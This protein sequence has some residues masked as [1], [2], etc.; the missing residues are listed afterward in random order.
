[1]SNPNHKLLIKKIVL[2]R[3]VDKIYFESIFKLIKGNGKKMQQKLRLILFIIGLIFISAV[4]PKVFGQQTNDVRYITLPGSKLWIDGTSNIDS[5]TCK[6]HYVAGYADL[7]HEAK[8]NTK[9]T[10]KDTVIVSVLVHS[11]DCGKDLMND[12]MYNAMKAAK[13]PVIKYELLDAHLSSH[14]D[15]LK[16]WFTLD[17]KGYLFIAGKKNAVKIKMQ[18]EKL[19]DGN[20]RL[21]GSKPLLMKNYGII[22]PSHF[23]GL[24]HAHNKLVVHFD[25]LAAREPKFQSISHLDEVLEK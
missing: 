13:F 2:F 8:A 12:D 22:P 15:S 10:G 6:S 5:F 7:D 21:V 19:P 24:I 14:P 17:T 16:G 3:R 20:Y 4:N 23:F 11:L 9:S 1:M 18:V 25:L